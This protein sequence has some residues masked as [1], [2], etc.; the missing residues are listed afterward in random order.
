VRAKPTELGQ[1]SGVGVY[2]HGWN[3]VGP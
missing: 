3:A 2:D 1:R